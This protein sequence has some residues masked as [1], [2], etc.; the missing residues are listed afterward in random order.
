MISASHQQ[1][2]RELKICILVWHYIYVYD[3]FMQIL[4]QTIKSFIDPASK[5]KKSIIQLFI[6]YCRDGSCT[7]GNIQRLTMAVFQRC[8]ACTPD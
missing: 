5:K 6:C 7:F 8:I 4:M 3:I 1:I 2:R